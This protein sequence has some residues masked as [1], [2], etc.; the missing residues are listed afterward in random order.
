MRSLCIL[1][2]MICIFNSPVLALSQPEQTRPLPSYSDCSTSISIIG[3]TAKMLTYQKAMTFC[4]A[5]RGKKLAKSCTHGEIAS[6]A[7]KMS[8]KVGGTCTETISCCEPLL[9]ASA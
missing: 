7:E 3:K 9:D 8:S 6:T 2:T 4:D 5:R 1:S